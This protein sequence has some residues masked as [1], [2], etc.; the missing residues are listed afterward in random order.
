VRDL[1][2]EVRESLLNFKSV[3][4]KAIKDNTDKFVINAL[5]AIVYDN[6]ASK[7]E[8]RAATT[9]LNQAARSICCDAPYF[10]PFYVLERASN[11]G[12]ACLLRLFCL[13]KIPT[14]KGN[15][16]YG[17]D[18]IEIKFQDK[19]YLFLMSSHAIDQL[20]Q[21]ITRSVG[22]TPVNLIDGLCSVWG[23]L[24]FEDV[25]IWKDLNGEHRQ[26]VGICTDLHVPGCITVGDKKRMGY[27]PVEVLK[28]DRGDVLLAKTF[29]TPIMKGTPEATVIHA[30]GIPDPVLHSIYDASEKLKEFGF[31][32]ELQE[33]PP[34]RD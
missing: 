1:K 9:A 34:A 30:K 8:M 4:N 13:N 15:G 26:V 21:R 5:N 23:H 7:K 28:T 6:H 17:K 12:V 32:M 27:C 14:S 22:K 3:V 24:F 18:L 20:S 11:G 25:L 33:V 16:W 29:L 2:M 31:Y 19:S 10:V